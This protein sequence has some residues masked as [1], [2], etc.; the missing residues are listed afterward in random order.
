MTEFPPQ[1]VEDGRWDPFSL[2]GLRDTM[3]QPLADAAP[4]DDEEKRALREQVASLQQQV[5][6]LQARGLAESSAEASDTVTQEEVRREREL[7]LVRDRGGRGVERRVK[8]GENE[9]E[10]DAVGDSE[11]DRETWRERERERVRSRV[12]EGGGV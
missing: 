4:G 12:T 9:S 5:A 6:A 2:W 3:L 7:G 11:R 10:R 8:D 1:P